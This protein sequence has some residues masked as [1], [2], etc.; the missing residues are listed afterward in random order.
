MGMGSER[1]VQTGVV[2]LEMTREPRVELLSE[3][4]RRDV[5][6]LLEAVHDVAEIIQQ[7]LVI[8][9]VLAQAVIVMLAHEPLLEGE[10]RRDAPEQVA[11]EGFDR[12]PVAVGDQL[13]MQAVD[14]IDQLAM[15]VIDR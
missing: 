3:L 12:G 4:A 5:E 10:M 8:A 6:V 14:E 7:T 9:L 11:E 15:L 1:L 13:V 2:G